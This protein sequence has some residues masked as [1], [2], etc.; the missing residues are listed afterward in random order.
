VGKSKDK[1]DMSKVKFFACHKIN[2]YA[3][4]C[5]NKKK[6]KKDPEVSTSTEVVKFTE[7]FEKGFSLITSLSASGSVVFGD[8]GEWFV[9]NGASWHMTRIRLVFLSFSEIHSD[10]YVP[11]GDSTRHAMTGVGCVRFKLEPGGFL[12]LADVLF[13]PELPIN[14]L[15][16]SALEVNGCGVVF[17][18]GHMFLYPEGATLDTTVFLGV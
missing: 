12:E 9:D 3:S 13:V 14:F 4:Q 10:C 16:V 11:C 7:K 17:F 1:K 8:I 5:Q 6:S 15:S 18:H 2:N